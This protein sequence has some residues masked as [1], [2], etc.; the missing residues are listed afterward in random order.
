MVPIVVNCTSSSGPPGRSRGSG[1]PWRGVTSGN[2]ECPNF[3][4]LFLYFPV[5]NCRMKRHCQCPP[6]RREG[7]ESPAPESHD[8]TESGGRLRNSS[9]RLAC[10]PF[11]NARELHS[12]EIFS[13][14]S[15][16]EKTTSQTC[17]A[18]DLPFPSFCVFSSSSS[19]KSELLRKSKLPRAV[20]TLRLAVLSDRL[21]L[22]P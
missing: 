7:Q 8:V 1:S 4:F 17:G 19:S 9:E 12:K 15:A 21:R 18:T 20:S 11:M 2:T 14:C 3:P 6:S 22:R 10:P 5:G 13:K 16:V